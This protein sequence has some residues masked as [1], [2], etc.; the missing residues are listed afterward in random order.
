MSRQ[1][2]KEFTIATDARLADSCLRIF[3]AA[4]ALLIFVFHSLFES[5]GEIARG[6][7]DPQQAVTTE[8][9][10]SFVANL[11]DH[12]YRFVSPD[13][14]VAGLGP[15]R[16]YAMMTFDDG[17]AN[18]LRAL[19]VLKEF[20]APAVFCIATNHVRTGKPF[21]WDVLYR[22]SHKRGWP[23]GKL[24]DARAA[25]KR[26][27]TCDIEK[28]LI[29]EFGSTAFQTVSDLD[30]PFTVAELAK[31]ASHPLVHIGNHTAD[32]AILTNYPPFEVREQIQSAQESLQEITGRVPAILAYPNGNVSRPS[33]RA[34]HEAGIRLGVTVQ[35]GRNTI[36][37]T[38]AKNGALLL[39]RYTLWGTRD[40]ATQCRWAQSPF[41]LQTAWAAICSKTIFT[42]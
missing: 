42:A 37:S 33:L 9:F 30:R 36:P 17:Y 20:Q 7:I 22:E 27:R 24:D 19:P 8:M 1:S 39:K 13:D 21:W 5:A 2:W 28:Q 16:Q 18:N 40:L 31:F 41:S 35:P 26:L 12:G 38:R 29:A 6:L 34:A 15:G 25:W 14:I 11:H 23:D 4:S 10:R 32:H 3:P